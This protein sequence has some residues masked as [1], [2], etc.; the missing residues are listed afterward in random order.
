MTPGVVYRTVDGGD[1]WVAVDAPP[2]GVQQL[3]VDPQNPSNI[4]DVGNFSVGNTTRKSSGGGSTWSNVSFPGTSI[5]SLVIDPH[6]AG[7]IVAFSTC[8][9]GTRS[10][11]GGTLPYLYRSTDGGAN[12]TKYA[13]P[14]P[15]TLGPFID[16]STNPSTVYDGFVSRSSD[17]GATWSALP[18]SLVSGGTTSGV[19][20]DP[21]G[22][23]YAFV[24]G[25]GMRCRGTGGR[26][27]RRPAVPCLHRFRPGLGL[28]V[29]DTVPVDASG[30]L[31]AAINLT[32]SSAFVSKLT[33]GGANLEFSTYL[34]SHPG[35]DGHAS[36]LAE[37]DVFGLQTWISSMALDA[38]GNVVVA[39]GVRG[40]DMAMVN[41]AQPKN[42]GLADAFAA[43]IAGDGSALLYSTY[44]GGSQDDGALAVAAG[45]HGDIVIAGDAWS[46]DLPGGVPQPNGYS[47]A[48]VTRLTPTAPVITSVLDAASF[49][50]AI[51][52]GSW[53]MIRGTNLANTA[54]TWRTDEIVNGALPTS[55]GGVSVTIDGQPAFV[56][57]ISPTQINV[58]APSNAAA[59]AVQV[60]VNNNGSIGAPATAQLQTYAPH[61]SNF[62][63]RNT[64]WLSGC[65]GMS[66]WQIREL[67]RERWERS[68]AMWWCCGARDSAQPI[69]QC[70]RA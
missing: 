7:N 67:F 4:Y 13:S 32:A 20:V 14:T 23:L 3:A 44:Y 52:A 28:S 66:P 31:F 43:V 50:P 6:A 65:R 5:A 16:G 33:S 59:A 63:L 35:L 30:T 45:P 46:R 58:Q 70:P 12:W 62:C 56:Y 27:G 40:A 39:G 55:L 2:Y 42:A 34:R 37:P 47:E 48:F 53:V 51:A 61:F 29:V 64:R 15:S 24:Y 69:R 26:P 17:G 25:S 18:P 21:N 36:Y 8:I 57:Y 10:G 9:I 22:T 41:A 60:V 54:R 49:Q 1:T 38:L 11:G 19:A 68:R